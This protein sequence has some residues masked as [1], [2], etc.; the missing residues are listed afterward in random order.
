[1][2]KA[3]GVRRIFNQNPQKQAFEQALLAL[4]RGNAKEAERICQEAMRRYPDDANLLCLSARALIRLEQF[5]AAKDQINA[6]LAMFPDFARPH[7]ILGELYL[8]Q[9]EP[10]L[11]V[12]AFKRAIDLSPNS[13]ILYDKL[14]TTLLKLGRAEEAAK[15]FQE[16]SQRSL[17]GEAI[18]IA[19]RYERDGELDSAEQIYH[20]LLPQDPENVEVLRRIGALAAAKKQYADAEVLLRQVVSL[21]PDFASAWADLV[22]VQMESQEYEEAVNSAECLV[23]LSDA[24][25][26]DRLALAN[27]YAMSGRHRDALAEYEKVAA[28]L[29]GHPG[30]LSGMGH[31]LKT[32]GRQEESIKIYKE[33][34]RANPQ[35]TE[36]WWGLANM[37]TYHFM[38]VEIQAMLDLLHGSNLKTEPTSRW[39]TSTPEANLCNALGTAFEGNGDYDRAFAYF[40]RG[41]RIRRRDEPYDP[42][43]TEYLH[44]RIIETFDRRFLAE[45]S[46]VGCSDAAPIFIVGL[47][48]TGSTLIEQILASHEIVEGTHELPE[49]GRLIATLP[50]VRPERPGYPENVTDLSDHAF[51]A[52]GCEYIDRT[53]KYRLGKAFFTDKSLNNYMHIGLLHIILPNAPIINVKR[54]P[55]DACLAIYKQLF[56]RGQSFSYDLEEVGEYYLQYQRLMEHWDKQLPG[57]ILHVRYE[58]VIADLQT[59]VRRILKYCGLPWDDN[60][61][62]FYSTS[63]DVRTASSEQVRRPIYTTSVNVWRNYEAHLGDLIQV[64]KPELLKLP[65]ADCPASLRDS[66][67]A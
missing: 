45:K 43:Q 57:K 26:L 37:K 35:H 13:F 1:M 15:A 10:L 56:A 59:Q 42:V 5:D 52:L 29:P 50:V 7:E 55:L 34:I 25:L 44:D 21:A 17:G 18:E 32:I 40:E 38:S 46:E 66:V 36:A 47:P 3:E 22:V 67:V 61:L 54:H 30:V 33:C 28:E 51:E 60:C 62:R 23:A 58:D 2:L 9:K 64:L 41:N 8:Q 16:C 6:A 39:L 49:I 24:G 53:R 20:K 14:G 63:R 65:V 4:Q 11:A 31:M 27:A 12:D 48:R 19:K